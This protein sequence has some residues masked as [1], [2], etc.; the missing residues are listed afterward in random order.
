MT[1]Q[2]TVRFQPDIK[3]YI[4][5]AAGETIAVNLFKGLEQS[6]T[7]KDGTSPPVSVVVVSEFT[8]SGGAVT[9][10]FTSLTGFN[11]AA[12]DATGLKLQYLAF[13]NKAGNGNLSI[14]PGA[15]NG[16][17]IPNASS[18][19]DLLGHASNTSWIDQKFNDDLVDVGSSDKTLDV[20]GTGTESFFVVLLFG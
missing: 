11:G 19:W 14:V 17:D 1:A 12:I 7:L 4:T 20:N 5:T 18:R 13:I 6:A 16:Y 15:T 9:I 10:D 8:L 2:A 3:D